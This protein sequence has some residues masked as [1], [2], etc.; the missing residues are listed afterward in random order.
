MLP[1]NARLTSS[2]D[3]A[4]ATKSGI[5]VTTPH[6]VGY[7]YLSRG[8]NPQTINSVAKCGLIINKSVGGSVARH[9][10]ARQVRH[11]IAPHV[12]SLPH[13]S[14]FVV[15]ALPKNGSKDAVTEISQLISKL[16]ER[17]SRN[18]VNK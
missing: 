12:A 8:E 14:L 1:K 10:L 15:R 5:R 6:F 16:L 13:N 3:F 4:R 2:T 17:A 9:R 7:L 11:A 18:S